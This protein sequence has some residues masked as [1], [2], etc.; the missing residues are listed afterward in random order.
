MVDP[1]STEL[2]G[3][4]SEIITDR[5]LKFIEQ[6]RERPFLAIIWFHAPHLPVVASPQ[7]AQSY[8]NGSTSAY[9]RNYYGCVTALDRQMGRIRAAL[10][11][12]E[13]ADNTMLTF[14]SD[15]GPEGN[16]R[17]PGKAGSFRGR[18]R[19][20]YEGGV[21]VPSLIEWPAKVKAGSVSSVASCTVDYFPTIR[22]I[23]GFD[24]PDDRPLD[25]ISLIPVMTGTISARPQPLAFHIRGKAAWHD[26][27]WK[28]IRP[29]SNAS[30]ELYNLESDPSE[31][32]NIAAEHS[33]KLQSMIKAWKQWKTSVEAS[34]S[35]SD[36]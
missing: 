24:M 31:S 18:K 36:Y 23:V 35:G 29:A 33:Q 14:C 17:A 28:A 3:D 27:K 15:N 7:D 11:D 6:H 9:E 16:D 8:E 21:R 4:D 22:E 10:R 2:R 20:L 13:I 19:S 32:N 34:D 12:W 5:A 1:E 26:D 30:W 25:G